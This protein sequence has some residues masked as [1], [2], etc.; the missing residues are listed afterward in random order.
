MPASASDE[1]SVRTC[2]P[3]GSSAKHEEGSRAVAHGPNGN[4]ERGDWEQDQAAQEGMEQ[5]RDAQEDIED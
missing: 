5:D 3:R 2:P 4:S 1:T